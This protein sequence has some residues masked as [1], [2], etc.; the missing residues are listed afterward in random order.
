MY[1]Y[2]IYEI[3]NGCSMFAIKLGLGVGLSNLKDCFLARDYPQKV[4]SEQIE[5]VVFGKQP[6]RK[7][8]SEQGVPFVATYHP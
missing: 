4:I 2:I 8:T 6:F 1:M 3:H 5:K 7:D